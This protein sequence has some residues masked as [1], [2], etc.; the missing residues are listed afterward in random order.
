MDNFHV[1]M[2]HRTRKVHRPDRAEEQNDT[3]QGRHA[4]YGQR[5]FY[6]CQGGQPPPP[7]AISGL[8]L[9]GLFRLQ[10]IE[11]K[12]AGGEICKL[13]GSVHFRHANAS[14]P[15]RLSPEGT[16]SLDDPRAAARRLAQGGLP[17]S[18]KTPLRPGRGGPGPHDFLERGKPCPPPPG[19][20]W[21]TPCQTGDAGSRQC[22]PFAG[23][24]LGTSAPCTPVGALAL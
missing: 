6:F 3:P 16:F 5:N 19:Y 23:A 11:L 22:G 12:A 15:L 18:Q 10:L 24:R 13:W 1:I 7:E 9:L 8:V 2:H 14:I 21:R 17:D 4:P 20:S